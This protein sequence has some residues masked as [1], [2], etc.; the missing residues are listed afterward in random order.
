MS[1]GDRVCYGGG[2]PGA[3][4]SHRVM[5]ADRLTPIP[6]GVSDEQA[7]AVMLKGMTV[8]YLLNRCYPVKKGE[9]VLFY[10]AA[11]GVGLLAGQWGAHLG[12]RMIGVASGPEK[13]ALAKANGYSECIDRRVE[14]VGARLKELTAGQGF[15]VVYDSVGRATF[16]LTLHALAPRGYFVSFGTTTG[17]L[18][19]VEAAVLQKLGSLYFT[20]PTLVTYNAKAEDL[21]ASAAAVFDLVRRGVLKVLIHQR[22]AMSDIAEAHRLLESGQTMGS[23]LILP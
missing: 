5:P 20:R 18:P 10:A 1:V 6:D 23:T 22:F 13:V 9:T 12:A 3:D 21:R 8:E 14:D 16:D 11:G 17:T 7:A 15:P 4:A 19:P 2:G